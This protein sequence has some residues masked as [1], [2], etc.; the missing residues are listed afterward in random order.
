MARYALRPDAPR[1]TLAITN[2]QLPELVGAA[3]LYGMRVGGS[4]VSLHFARHGA[5]THADFL[6]VEGEEIKVQI[7]IG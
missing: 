6:G 7:E 2:P 5:R 1:R 3:D 4:R